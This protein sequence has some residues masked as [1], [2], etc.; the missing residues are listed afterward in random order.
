MK[1]PARIA[2]LVVGIIGFIVA[3][4]IAVFVWLMRGALSPDEDGILA[5]YCFV[6][7]G[8][9]LLVII[10]AWVWGRN[11]ANEQT[12]EENDQNEK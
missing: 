2:L 4:P 1:S 10:T 8:T 9:T 6:L 11:Q 3:A 12:D 5:L 7:P